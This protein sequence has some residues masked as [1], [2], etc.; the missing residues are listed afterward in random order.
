MRIRKKKTAATSDFEQFLKD[1]NCTYTTEVNDQATEYSFHFQAAHFVAS[2]RKNNGS[3]E[4]TFPYMSSAP[5][6]MLA[7][8]RAERKG[9]GVVKITVKPAGLP[10]KI[11][12]L[13]VKEASADELLR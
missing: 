4:I 12:T 10:E 6:D 8:V 5:I 11:I 1:Y 3:M 2:I 7:V 9:K 13:H